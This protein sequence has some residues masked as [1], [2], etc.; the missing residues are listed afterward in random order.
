MGFEVPLDD[1]ETDSVGGFDYV[2][3]GQYHAEVTEYTEEGGKKGEDIVKIEI[4]RG[5]TP[6]QEGKECK[7]Y[8]KR[9]FDKWSLRK[10]IALALATDVITK[11]QLDEHKLNK[12]SP[13]FDFSN[14]VG[15]QICLAIE[16]NEYEGKVTSRLAWDNLWHPADGRAARIPL[17]MGKIEKAG[18][19]LPADRDPNGG[20]I[21]PAAPDAAK[22][23]AKKEQL[24][25]ANMDELLG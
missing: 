15:K 5:T 22:P 9:D 1:V 14:I 18:I 16:E 24:Q 13:T 11:K 20:T 10:I 17:N 12:T 25:A 4:L 19:K 2:R 21:K 3:S 7:L 8:F 23:D 6:K